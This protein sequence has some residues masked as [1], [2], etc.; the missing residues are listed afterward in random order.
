MIEDKILKGKIEFKRDL[1]EKSKCVIKAMLQ[2]DKSKRP[3]AT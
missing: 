2:A 1:S 3:S